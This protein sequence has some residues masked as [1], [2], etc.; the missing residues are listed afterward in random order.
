MVGCGQLARTA[1]IP[2]L[3]RN[4]AVEIIGLCDSS[5]SAISSAA[6]LAPGAPRYDSIDALLDS[7]SVDAVV[8]SL[9]SHLHTDAAIAAFRRGAHVYL[10]KPIASQLDDAQRIIEAWRTSNRIGMI[11]HNFRFN[12]LASK[13]RELIAADS[14]GGVSS[15]VTRYFTSRPPADSWR[16]NRATG[17]GALLDL[18]VHHIDF[19]RF[20]LNAEAKSV[21]ARIESRQSDH[22][23]AAISLTMSN[24]STADINVEFA[25]SFR[26][27][28]EVHGEKATL[29]IDRAHSVDVGRSAAGRQIGLTSIIR[30]HLPTPGRVAYWALRRRSPFREPSY[31][32]ALS[33]FVNAV[34]SSV[35]PSPDLLDG[36]AALAV[37]DAAERSSASGKPVSVE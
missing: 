25:D 8:I 13:I 9:P 32:I 10:E 15:I 29:W 18:A 6:D 5:S 12:P 34:T 26:D 28:I 20:A 4:H 35:Q 19:V 14:I 24:G 11:G 37:V 1:H 17:G 33:S 16:H 2:L 3:E 22:D 27:R 21:S 30:A 7:H 23:S 36:L 31:A